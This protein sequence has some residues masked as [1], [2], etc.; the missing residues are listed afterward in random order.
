MTTQTMNCT[1]SHCTREVSGTAYN[2]KDYC[3]VCMPS[4]P[5]IRYRTA[6]GCERCT[7]DAY[8]PHYNCRCSGHRAHCTS[9]YCY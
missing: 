3:E 6:E 5:T 2:G 8:V 9:D 4:V 1:I 7:Y